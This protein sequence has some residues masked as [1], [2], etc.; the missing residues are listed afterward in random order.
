V[1]GNHGETAF[2]E[3]V[4]RIAGRLVADRCST[5]DAFAAWLE[6]HRRRSNGANAY[7]ILGGALNVARVASIPEQDQRMVN[8]FDLNGDSGCLALP[9][10]QVRLVWLP[11]RK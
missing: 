11:V 10:R 6:D 1:S 4:R 7:T 9:G 3:P 5:G 2:E 8:V